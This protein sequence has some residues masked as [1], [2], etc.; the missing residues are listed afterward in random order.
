MSWI[1]LSIQASSKNISVL[2]V[3]PQKNNFMW[4]D[5]FLTVFFRSGSCFGWDVNISI[6]QFFSPHDRDVSRLFSTC[7]SLEHRKVHH[8]KVSSLGHMSMECAREVGMKSIRSS[9][10]SLFLALNP[11]HTSSPSNMIFFLCLSYSCGEVHFEVDL[12]VHKHW[13]KY[14]YYFCCCP[15]FHDHCQCV[16]CKY[17]VWVGLILGGKG[18]AD[19]HVPNQPVILEEGRLLSKDNQVRPVRCVLPLPVGPAFCAGAVISTVAKLT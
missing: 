19:D 10:P 13:H 3:C 15:G 1:H 17:R 18:S 5:A 6:Q 11:S 2:I 14:P 9:F 7:T 16:L 4:R 12:T 8:S